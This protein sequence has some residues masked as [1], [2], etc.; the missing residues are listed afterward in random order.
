MVE[1]GIV[2]LVGFCGDC[3]DNVFVVNVVFKF[4]LIN[5]GRFWWCIDDVKL[6]IVE[7]LVGIIRNVCMKF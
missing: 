5:C 2:F 3:Y 6:V 4:E 1:F 7:W